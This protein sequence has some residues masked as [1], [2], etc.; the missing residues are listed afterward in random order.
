[1]ENKAVVIT[2]K[3]VAWVVFVL[4]VVWALS[5][6]ISVQPDSIISNK[7]FLRNSDILGITIQGQMLCVLETTLR[8][9]CGL[10]VKYIIMGFVDPN[11]AFNRLFK[12]ITA[13]KE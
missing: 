7:I 10:V 8:V 1:M 6:F 11:N 2:V 12:K 9:V 13:S 3:V 5:L 4:S